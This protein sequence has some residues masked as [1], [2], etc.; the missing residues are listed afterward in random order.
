MGTGRPS[1]YNEAYDNLIVEEMS[2]GKSIAA[3]AA[4]IGVAR[5]TIQEWEK[6]Y[7][8]FSVAL[9]AGKAKCAAW[10]EERLRTIATNPQSG[11]VTA[12][13]FGLK[14][15]ASEDWR[16]KQELEHSGTMTV[17]VVKFSENDL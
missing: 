12:A 15:M 10:W 13:I 7:P 16:D 11:N 3:F 5:S 17:Q 2:Q 14:N 1:K 6:Q 4:E 8:T 9:K